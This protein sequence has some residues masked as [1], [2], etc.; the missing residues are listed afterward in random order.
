MFFPMSFGKACCFA[1]GHS[2]G[3]KCPVSVSLGEDVRWAVLK[4]ERHTVNGIEDAS[5]HL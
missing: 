2:A 4:V 5:M 1:P 3:G